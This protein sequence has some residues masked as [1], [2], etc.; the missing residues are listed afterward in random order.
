MSHASHKET[1]T[2]CRKSALQHCKSKQLQ[3]GGLRWVPTSRGHSCMESTDRYL[4]C[5]HK[6]LYGLNQLGGNCKS[7][8]IC[9]TSPL[10][11]RPTARKKI[12]CSSS[13]QFLSF[14]V[15]TS[16]HGAWH[17]RLIHHTQPP[18]PITHP[19]HPEACTVVLD[20]GLHGGGCGDMACRCDW[21]P[22][23]LRSRALPWGTQRLHRTTSG[24]PA[25]WRFGGRRFGNLGDPP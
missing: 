19:F 9:H 24:D 14:T 8:R 12:R 7:K 23:S 6:R 10:Q 11:Y 1:A 20:G 17:T 13:S 2:C 22:P 15:T 3:Q 25:A 4:D 16:K 18:I 5:R 21:L